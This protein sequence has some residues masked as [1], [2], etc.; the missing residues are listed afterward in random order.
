MKIRHKKLI[1]SGIAL[2]LAGV[3]GAGAL[4]QT[5]VSVQASYAMMPGIEQI[6]KD[7]SE[8]KPFKILE[9]VDNTNE[10]EIGYYVS[11]QEPYVKLYEY[12]Y[13]DSA[14][15]EHTKKFQS[16]EEGLSQ[17][18]DPVKRKEFAMNVKLDTNGNIDDTKN[19]NIKQIQNVC[20]RSGGEGQESD[21]P[22]S[23]SEYREKYIL[24][25][26]EKTTGSWENDWK[27][28]DF[29]D[30]TGKSKSYK[31]Q[32]KGN[33]QENTAGTGDYTKKEQQYYP[34]RQGTDD[35][36]NKNEKV[37]EN[38]QNFYYTGSEEA[39]SPY[40]LTFES[41][42]NDDLNKN[43]NENGEKVA[44]NSI[45][46]D[47]N[48]ADGNYGYYENVYE[49]L[50]AEIVQNLTGGIF[51]FPGENPSVDLNGAKKLLD[52]SVKNG[53]AFSSGE[54][55]F[56]SVDDTA[57]QTQATQQD[58]V[59]EVPQAEE[60]NAD[61]A[62]SDGDFTSGA[63]AAETEDSFDSTGT[64]TDLQ[65]S[66]EPDNNVSADANTI[67]EATAGTEDSSDNVKSNPSLFLCAK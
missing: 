66:A 35:A 65:E 20:Y 32:V 45:L 59:P 2:S 25:P 16:L 58:S 9:I 54:D 28:I 30:S 7:T 12:T 8:E 51:K 41:V 33:Y 44:N 55:E 17:I 13:Q 4:L 1:A 52:T 24:T 19:T 5:S 57:D 47:Y 60:G 18:S 50:T 64:G 63:D 39:N 11:G 6:V 14:N 48:S 29:T 34:I 38:I 62:F 22:L 31:V 46:A 37:R 42:S 27:K 23:Y 61:S 36:Q 21:Y 56:M 15:K 10:A 3:L 53:T 40:F 43:F 26:D 49:D 67:S